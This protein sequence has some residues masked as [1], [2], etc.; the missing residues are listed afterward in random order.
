M[1]D[2]WRY[3]L[4]DLAS[5]LK[6]LKLKPTKLIEHTLKKI[7]ELNDKLYMFIYVAEDLAYK[8]AEELEKELEEGVQRSLIHGLPIAVKDVFYT[9]DMPTTAGSKILRNFQ[10]S[11]DA[12]VVGRLREAGAIIIG[13]TNMHEFAFGVTNK[14][15]HYGTSRNPWD[16]ERI[17]GGSSGGS[18]VAVATEISVL[19]LGT[20]TAGS[21][22][23]PS[24]LCGV[25]GF[26]PTYGLLSLE[27]VVPLS[28]SLDTVGPITKSVEDTALVLDIMTGGRHG[29]AENLKEEID[30]ELR[31]L[32]PAKIIEE[33]ASSEVEGVFWR[34]IDKIVSAGHKV[35]YLEDLD[36]FKHASNSRYIIVLSESATYHLKWIRDYWSMYD[37]DVAGRILMGYFI[38]APVYIHAQR[39]RMKTIEKFKKVMKDHD[40]ILLPTVSIEAPRIDEEKVQV[41]E[42]EVSVRYALLC[43]TEVFNSLYAPAISIPCGL[44]K[45]NLPIGLQIVTEPGQ[46]KKLLKI[47][48]HVE[49]LIKRLPK[50]PVS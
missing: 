45:N 9:R 38:P 14:N 1:L 48:S 17:S 29:F 5:Q 25:V 42:K 18:A 33:L 35:D 11:Y 40:A 27:G 6:N 39:V 30:R 37:P 24:A 43:M 50:P 41:K 20:D 28:W 8:Q 4:R 13:K 2:L 47:A 26:K 21:I 49:R 22:R 31:F 34:T 36:W 23:I 32:V 19:G 16:L 7:R 15:P 3:T 10:T 12:E 46:D 44:S